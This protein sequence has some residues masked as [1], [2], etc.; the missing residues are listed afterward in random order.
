MADT[1]A[2]AGTNDADDE[3]K[4]AADRWKRRTSTFGLILMGLA[5]LGS[6]WCSFQ[7]SLWDGIQTFKLM[8]SAGFSRRANELTIRATQQRVVDGALFVEYARDIGDEK[9]HAAEFIFARMR[10]GL[11][12]AIN[13]WMAMHPLKNPDAPVTPFVMAEYQVL[14]DSEVVDIN[15]RADA[16]HDSAQRAN[17]TS[18]SYTLLTVLYSTALFLAGLVSA[19][20]ER[21][22][23]LVTLIMGVVV[24]AIASGLLLRLPVA[25]IG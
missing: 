16:A 6:S 5:T 8:D 25:Q 2:D 20:H 24:F 12:K 15:A 17:R 14:L 10:P 11:Q 1:I 9:T 22:S 23:R 21:R 18:D 13:A 3:K 4:T 7:S 19:I